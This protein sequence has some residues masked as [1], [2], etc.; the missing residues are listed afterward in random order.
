[1]KLRSDLGTEDVDGELIVLDKTAGKVHQLNS[2]A[3]FVWNCLSD[4]L[5]IEDIALIISEECG[6]EPETALTDVRAVLA[7]FEA[8]ALVVK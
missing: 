7:Q 2:S 5:A 8:L 4:G 1:M 6:I 3:S